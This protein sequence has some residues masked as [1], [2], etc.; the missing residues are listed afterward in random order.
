MAE[1]YPCLHLTAYLICLIR[2]STPA[3]KERRRQQPY[4]NWPPIY[5]M[6]PS[7]F[8]SLDQCD[9]KPGQI[10]LVLRVPPLQIQFEYPPCGLTLAIFYPRKSVVCT[11]YFWQLHWLLINHSPNLSNH[12]TTTL[13]SPIGLP[14]S[15][16]LTTHQI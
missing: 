7:G 16:R 11:H 4:P 9:C 1:A 14:S 3:P 5:R 13:V 6:T 15:L 2:D 10:Q 12:S 8:E